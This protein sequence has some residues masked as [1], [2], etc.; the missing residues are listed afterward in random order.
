MGN[1][2]DGMV[3]GTLTAAVRVSSVPARTSAIEREVVR[4]FDEHREPLLRYILSFGLSMHDGEEV[5]Q[6]V[7]LALFRHLRGGGLRRNLPGWIFTVAH[8]LALRQRQTNQRSESI[9][10]GDALL[11]QE[12]VDDAPDPEAQ[13]LHQERKRRLLRVVKTLPDQDQYCLRLRAEGLRYREIARVLGIS[14]GSV[15]TSL[16]R[17][18]GRLMCLDQ[19]S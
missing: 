19:R 8:N 6:E 17:S 15:A 14:L 12:V 9:L 1:F 13:V 11:A 3:E 7:F 2:P 18:L 5:L 4:L 16:A 10:H